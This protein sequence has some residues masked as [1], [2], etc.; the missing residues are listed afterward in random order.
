M[1]LALQQLAKSCLNCGPP[2]VL[3]ELGQPKELK[4]LA[5]SLVIFAVC[6]PV[7]CASQAYPEYRSTVASHFLPIASNRSVP[8][9]S[10]GRFTELGSVPLATGLAC[11]GR[12]AWHGEHAAI[13]CSISFFICGQ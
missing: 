6:V 2:S 8:I 11:V 7:S 1:E 5:S 13:A 3:M 12:S 9:S 4:M 10:I